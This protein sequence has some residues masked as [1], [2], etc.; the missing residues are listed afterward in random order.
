MP[1]EA[2]DKRHDALA[3]QRLSACESELLYALVDEGAAHPVQF[4]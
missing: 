1:P 3:H 4:L 2:L